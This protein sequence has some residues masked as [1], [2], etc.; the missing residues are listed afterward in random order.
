[1]KIIYVLKIFIDKKILFID[2]KILYDNKE[3]L[4]MDYYMIKVFNWDLF[5]FINNN[6]FKNLK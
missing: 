2:K 3:M 4:S 5:S 6:K 1:M